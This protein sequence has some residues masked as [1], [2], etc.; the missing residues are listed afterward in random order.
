MLSFKSTK[1]IVLFS[2]V[3]FM[4]VFILSIMTLNFKTE[5][6]WDSF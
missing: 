2:K 5:V 6:K 4:I 1:F 3:L